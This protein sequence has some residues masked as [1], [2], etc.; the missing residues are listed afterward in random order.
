M[1]PANTG[2]SAGSSN[3][4]DVSIDATPPTVACGP[5]PVFVLQGPGGLVSATVTDAL[6]GPAAPVVSAPAD[7]ST[8]GVHSVLLAGTDNAG[9]STIAAC[10]YVVAYNFLGFLPPMPYEHVKAGST[11]PLRFRL[12]NAAGE[13]IPD[14]EALALVASCSV[15]IQ[16]TGGDP[17]PGCA[18]YSSG[19]DRF[20]FKLKTAKGLTG[21][22]HVTVVVVDGAVVINSE[23]SSVFVMR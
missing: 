18:S 15:R 1:T 17:V 13:P 14:A 5:T 22:H 12:G 16:F 6:S 4:V 20:D 23:P 8:A 2:A 21:P 19:P 10:P 7:V 11:I 9:N 3:S